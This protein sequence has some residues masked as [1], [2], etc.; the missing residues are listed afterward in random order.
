MSPPLADL[1]EGPMTLGAIGLSGLHRLR[2]RQAPEAVVFGAAP[3]PQS[4]RGVRR[5]RAYV[6]RPTESGASRV[7]EGDPK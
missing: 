3:E 1:L 4:S 5:P 2:G 6:R 7:L